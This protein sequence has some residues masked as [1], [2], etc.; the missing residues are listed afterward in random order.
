MTTSIIDKI[1]NVRTVRVSSRDC[2]PGPFSQSRDSGL[3]LTGSRDPGTQSGLAKWVLKGFL[4]FL[5]NL[6]TLKSKMYVVFSG[7][8]FYLVQI[9]I[10]V[11]V[12][13]VQLV[14]R[15]L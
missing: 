14:Y 5:K 12:T 7:C 4:G 10:L 9:A 1:I 15:G 8:L 2:N 13:L 6:K 3:A 11:F